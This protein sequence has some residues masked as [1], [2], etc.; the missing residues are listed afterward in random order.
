MTNRFAD[1][2]VGIYDTQ[3]QLR[4]GRKYATLVLPV[5][6]W[7][8]NTGNLTFEKRKFDRIMDAGLIEKLDLYFIQYDKN[9]HLLSEF[10]ICNFGW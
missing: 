2:K 8:N 3:I 6:K 7:R 4:Y 1:I 5:V 10:L 9:P